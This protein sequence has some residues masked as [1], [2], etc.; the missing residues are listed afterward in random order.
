MIMLEKGS[1]CASV[2]NVIYSFKDNPNQFSS[3]KSGLPKSC[4]QLQGF[5]VVFNYISNNYI[6]PYL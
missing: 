2:F 3:R 6:F 1:S 5:K 4:K